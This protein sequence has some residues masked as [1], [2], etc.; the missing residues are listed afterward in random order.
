MKR[1]DLDLG[2]LHF[3]TVLAHAGRDP[4]RSERA[5][6]P[7]I[8]RATTLLADDVAELYDA[9][10]TYA[11]DG[12]AVQEA[13]RAALVAIEGGAGAVLAPS[14]LTACTL[15]ILAD[16]IARSAPLHPEHAINGWRIMAESTALVYQVQRGDPTGP[17]ERNETLGH[18]TE[19]VIQA[20]R[21]SVQVICGR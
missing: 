8:H 21:R 19:G 1:D 20:A 16:S 13:L 11:L 5:V 7:P 15:A 9:P 14:G 3:E 4:A 2:Q 10:K 12:M 6:N 18:T 17:P